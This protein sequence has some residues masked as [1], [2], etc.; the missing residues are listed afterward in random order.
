TSR[1]FGAKNEAAEGMV[2]RRLARGI[3]LVSAGLDFSLH[4]HDRGKNGRAIQR[5]EL[6]HYGA[7]AAMEN[8]VDDRPSRT[9]ADAADDSALG[10]NHLRGFG[11][12]GAFCR[13]SALENG[14]G[15]AGIASAFVASDGNF[16]CR[17]IF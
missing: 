3:L 13:R 6:V 7:R 17:A 8:G 10:I 1:V 11:W 16:L 12:T 9:L 14:S 5:P 2:E 15:G 4:L